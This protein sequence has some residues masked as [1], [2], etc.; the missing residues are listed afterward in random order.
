MPILLVVLLVLL[1]CNYFL[2]LCCGARRP[3]TGSQP[4]E[5]GNTARSPLWVKTT[6][7]IIINDFT[8][9]VLLL[10]LL[11]LV[12]ALLFLFLLLIYPLP[13]IHPFSPPLI[14]IPLLYL[15]VQLLPLV[16][17]SSPPDPPGPPEILG[18]TE[19]AYTQVD[20]MLIFL[21]DISSKTSRNLHKKK[22]T[23]VPCCKSQIFFLWQQ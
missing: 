14:L 5:E 8:Q 22:G 12:V 9:S 11:I 7:C 3:A 16:W 17:S 2:Q 21:L 18:D 1:M 10:L 4:D 19:S 15:L 6:N 13:P 20:E 23:P